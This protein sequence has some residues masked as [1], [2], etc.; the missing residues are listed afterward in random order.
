MKSSVDT[1]RLYF[2]G[3]MIQTIR[4]DRDGTEVGH[5]GRLFLVGGAGS[6]ARAS[7]KV[8]EIL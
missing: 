3:K 1:F 7:M 4:L 5:P 2:D 6:A 8:I